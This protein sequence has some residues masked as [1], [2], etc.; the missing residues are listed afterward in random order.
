MGCNLDC[1]S[2]RPLSFTPGGSSRLRLRGCGG[3]RA[4]NSLRA[5]QTGPCTTAPQ[6]PPCERVSPAP[7]RKRAQG[8][9][10]FPQNASQSTKSSKRSGTGLPPP[11]DFGGHLLEPTIMIGSSV[12]RRSSSVRAGGGE[13]A[14]HARRERL[15][16]EASRNRWPWTA[17]HHYATVP[18]LARRRHLGTPRSRM[19]LMTQT[20]ASLLPVCPTRCCYRRSHASC[21]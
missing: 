16:R 20:L 6:Q 18:L 14:S 5:R 17:L 21:P 9:K 12:F 3:R 8:H 2:R 13:V 11:S 10:I 19:P 7:I 4:P 15:R 1:L